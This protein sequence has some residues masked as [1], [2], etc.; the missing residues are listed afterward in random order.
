MKKNRQSLPRIEASHGRL[1]YNPEALSEA[2]LRHSIRQQHIMNLF[3]TTNTLMAKKWMAGGDIY[4]KTLLRICNAF[5]LDLLQFF[6]YDG[7]PISA[8][9]E[10]VHRLTIGGRS[11]DSMLRQ[12]NIPPLADE[13]P[14]KAGDEAMPA[15]PDDPKSRAELLKQCAAAHEAYE[16]RQ[17][18]A[19]LAQLP[20]EDLIE[21][22]IDVQRKAS[23]HE[24]AALDDLRAKMQRVIDER[25]REI[26]S[27]KT[28]LAM[29]RA[30]SVE[31]QNSSD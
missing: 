28:E 1:D 21:K 3:N 10:D 4:V 26:L 8:T 18:G 27:L 24:Q 14:H 13:G 5:K 2:M 17:T 22:F 11:V 25:D 30:T 19:S 23:E 29:A 9:L 20:V 7:A 16:L 6:L 31:Q 15:P 12:R